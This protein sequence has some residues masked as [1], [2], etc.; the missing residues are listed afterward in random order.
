M[1]HGEASL[2]AE[3]AEFPRGR[4]Q[5][6]VPM[7]KGVSVGART[8]HTDG[9][10]RDRLVHKVVRMCIECARDF[11]VLCPRMGMHSGRWSLSL[12]GGGDV[13]SSFGGR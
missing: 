6:Y 5:C 7:E 13:R 12:G 10:D 8:R 1:R 11:A 3:R 4:L 2:D 9:A